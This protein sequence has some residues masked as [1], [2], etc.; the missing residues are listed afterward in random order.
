[1]RRIVIRPELVG[2]ICEIPSKPSVQPDGSITIGIHTPGLF[3]WLR[4]VGEERGDDY[5]LLR[6]VLDTIRHLPS[7]AKENIVEGNYE[8][9]GDS[10]FVS[11]RRNKETPPPQA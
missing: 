6:D 11:R 10:V 3:A 5:K 9:K 4:R 2:D 8:V 1:M 7:E